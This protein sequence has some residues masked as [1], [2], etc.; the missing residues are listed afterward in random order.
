MRLF[1]VSVRKRAARYTILTANNPEVL[2]LV[3]W[4]QQ[5]DERTLEA[6]LVAWT[7][8][9]MVAPAVAQQLELSVGDLAAE[10]LLSSST[11]W[12]SLCGPSAGVV[13]AMAILQMFV[14]GLKYRTK[15]ALTG[16]IHLGG[17]LHRVE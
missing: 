17:V 6:A 16:Q 8:A 4:D 12:Y 15:Q 3:G 7:W 13:V 14:S 9:R 11:S 10:V 2:G 1:A 5:H